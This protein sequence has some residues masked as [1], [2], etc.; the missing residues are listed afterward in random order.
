MATQHLDLDEQEQLAQLKDFWRKY[1]DA[2]SWAVTIVVLAFAAWVG[3]NWWE[4]R[5]AAQASTLY[6]AFDKAVQTADVPKVDRALADLGADYGS[7]MYAQQARLQAAKLYVDKGKLDA[8]KSAL[9]AVIDKAPDDGYKALA[10]LRL[11][12]V[13]ADQKNFD[14]ALK[15][16]NEEV[17]KSFEALANDR[18]GD[19]LSLQGQK[20]QAKAAYELA[21]KQAD[22][23]S[24]YRGMIEVKMRALG[25]QPPAAASSAA[26]QAQPG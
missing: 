24:P 17:P 9:Q 5:K 7:T 26:S 25:A 3:Y 14:A 15:L 4:N 6:E 1:G 16:V 8:A 23:N 20:A 19:I 18:R 13:L 21:Y 12:G 22:E 2:I 10:R 11:A